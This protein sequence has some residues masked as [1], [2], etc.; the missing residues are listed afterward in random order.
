MKLELPPTPFNVVTSSGGGHSPET[1]ADMCV[2]K[3]I[4][5]ADTAH[6]A[7][8]EQARAFR[9]QMLAV[10]L[11]HVN[12]AIEQDRATVAAKLRE[13]GYPDLAKQLKGL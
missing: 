9:Q 3:L 7:L 1:I 6:P 11:Y 5:V 4:S 10:V 2:D 13:A 12:I 8:R